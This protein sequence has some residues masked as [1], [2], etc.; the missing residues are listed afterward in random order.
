MRV[1]IVTPTLNADRYLESCL[2]SVARNVR[3]GIEVEHVIVDGGST[4]RTLWLAESFGARILT[5][6]DRGIFDAIN[7]GSFAATGDLLGFLGAD[8]L[9]LDGALE[10]LAAAHHDSGARWI[11][12]AVHW[13]DGEGRS[14]GTVAPP[15]A[16]MTPAIYACLG[17]SC[18]GHMA[19]YVSRDLFAELGGFNI[20]FRD[21]GDYDFFA[22]A[23]RSAPCC[24]IPQALAASR[25]TGE[26]NSAIHPE[27]TRRE[28]DRVLESYGPDDQHQRVI[29]RYLMKCWVN[30]RNLDWCARKNLRRLRARRRDTPS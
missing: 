12:G 4:D 3:P 14:L 8:D 26:N 6:K 24:R 2:A 9:L 20:E 18:V 28:C 10:H 7:K 15:P 21:A 22:R 11:S 30:G 25:L 29:Y 19:T 5:G 16:W 17:W 13:I 27:R 1:S 23:M